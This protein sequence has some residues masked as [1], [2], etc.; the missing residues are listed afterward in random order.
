MNNHVRYYVIETLSH[1]VMEHL[2]PEEINVL[3]DEDIDRLLSAAN[4]RAVNSM[5]SKITA[6]EKTMDSLKLSSIFFQVSFVCGILAALIWFWI[7]G[8]GLLS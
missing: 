7:Y 6:H 3:S 5:N 8:M 1:D 4:L 2:D